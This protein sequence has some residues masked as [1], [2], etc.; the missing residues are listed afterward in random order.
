MSTGSTNIAGGLHG[1][2]HCPTRA[3]LQPAYA[4][5][6]AV[7]G[8]PGTAALTLFSDITE[9]ALQDGLCCVVAN[10]MPVTSLAAAAYE[11]LGITSSYGVQYLCTFLC[12]LQGLGKTCLY[13]G[14]GVNDLVALSA[15]DVG[16]SVGS[17]DSSAGSVISIAEASVAGEFP[18]NTCTVDHISSIMTV[19]LSS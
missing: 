12:L 1:Q 13:C 19:P 2:R 5:G 10:A 16:V 8:S 17:G 15:A 14:D 11:A 6:T 9:V 3:T 18:C 4:I 7:I